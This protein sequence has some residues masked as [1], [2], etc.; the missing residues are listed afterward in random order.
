M[1]HFTTLA[2]LHSPRKSLDWMDP[3]AFPQEWSNVLGAMTLNMLLIYEFYLIE[4]MLGYVVT[5]PS[6]LAILAVAHKHIRTDFA[7]LFYMTM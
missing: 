1:G 7:N 3:T 2:Y 4:G 6:F 5:I